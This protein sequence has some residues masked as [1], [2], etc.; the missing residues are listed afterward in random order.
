MADAQGKNRRRRRRRHASAGAEVETKANNDLIYGGER[1]DGARVVLPGK[2]PD[3]LYGPGQEKSRTPGISIPFAEDLALMYDQSADDI[4]A[5]REI[6]HR[7]SDVCASARIIMSSIADTISASDWSIISSKQDAFWLALARRKRNDLL[8]VMS[9][10]D[11]WEEWVRQYVDWL[12]TSPTGFFSELVYNRNNEI[13]E[14]GT[15]YGTEPRPYYR[16]GMEV[17]YSLDKDKNPVVAERSINEAAG[18]WWKPNGGT[19]AYSLEWPLYH[20]VVTGAYGRGAWL[21][22]R[23]RAEDIRVRLSLASAVESYFKDVMTGTDKSGIL[24]MNNI[25]W[26]KLIEQIDKNRED[27]KKP[28]APGDKSNRGT[29][30]YTYNTGERQGDI[31]FTSFRSFPSDVDIVELMSTAQEMVAA[32]YGVKSQ[33]VDTQMDGGGR[34]GNAS[35]AIQSDAQEPGV[36]FIMKS[37]ERFLSG[38]WLGGLPLTFQFAGGVSAH[39]SVKIDNQMRIAQIVTQYGDKLSAEE[40]K[41]LAITL[42]APHS[43]FGVEVAS[44]AEGITKKTLPE[45]IASVWTDLFGEQMP[46]AFDNYGMMPERMSEIMSDFSAIALGLASIPAIVKS[47]GPHAFSVKRLEMKAKIEKLCNEMT[48][49]FKHEGK[50][51]VTQHGTPYECGLACVALGEVQILEAGF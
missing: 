7:L 28:R 10:R 35:R 20:Q 44:S 4:F 1:V 24:V 30:F 23:S 16:K 3:E 19:K 8:Q 13:V 29:M 32:G 2:T 45:T 25:A 6:I 46:R 38:V 42:G 51:I 11:G 5:R 50:K 34:F 18:I 26:R 39:D 14:M 41:R 12:L 48:E 17:F 27:R 31:K 36:Q 15:I 37:I 43:V 40:A 33:R 9:R 21:E 22:G 49:T 47:T